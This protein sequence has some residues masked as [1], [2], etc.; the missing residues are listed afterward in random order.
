MNDARELEHGFSLAHDTLRAYDDA[1]DD[2]LRILSQE[3][4]ARLDA[5][6]MSATI[7]A[8]CMTPNGDQLSQWR[9]YTRN[10]AGFSLGFES[11]ALER[12]ERIA[13]MPALSLRPVIYEPVDQRR[14]VDKAFALVG[15]LLAESPNDATFSSSLDHAASLFTSTVVD[16]LPTFKDV[17]FGEEAEWRLVHARSSDRVS[18]DMSLHLSADYLVP[19]VE[20]QIGATS[21]E[22]ACLPLREVV[23]GPQ[24]DEVRMRG[25]LQVLMAKHGLSGVVL[26]KSAIPLR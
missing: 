21:A 17:S 2:E 23:I 16:L 15:T 1:G 19:H 4:R 22:T 3:C 26:R 25:A 7:F 6:R 5:A 20:L 8:F 18:P 11:S 13:G 14:L 10:G 24:F 9:G 12:R